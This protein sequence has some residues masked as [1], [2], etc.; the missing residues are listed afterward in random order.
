MGTHVLH[1]LA[2]TLDCMDWLPGM[3]EGQLRGLRAWSVFKHVQV[4]ESALVL[5]G[6]APVNMR[7]LSPVNACCSRVPC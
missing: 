1:S 3:F 2:L 5:A 7:G 6:V 4:R